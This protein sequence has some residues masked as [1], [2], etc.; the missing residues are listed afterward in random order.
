MLPAPD[1]RALVEHA[2][3]MLWRAGPEGGRDHF[4]AT[5]LAFTGRTLEEERGDGWLAGVHPEDR[6]GWAAAFR[7]HAATQSP[8][9]RDLRLR[10]RDGVHRWIR[11][12]AVP[13]EQGGRFAGFI[14]ACVDVHEQK[15]AEASRHAFL[16]MIAHELRTPLMSLR[17]AAHF[18]GKKLGGVEGADRPLGIIGRQ[19]DRLARTAFELAEV[20]RLERG[21]PPDLALVPLDLGPLVE[22]AARECFAQLE[23]QASG[24]TLEIAVSA[25]PCVSADAGR[26]SQVVH[27]LV[28]NAVRYSPGGGA[29][30]VSVVSTS[31]GALFSVS[32]RGVGI[33]KDEIPRVGTRYY[34]A[35]NAKAAHHRGVGA[36]LAVCRDV[37][38]AH[39]GTLALRS[40]LGEGTTAEVFLPAVAP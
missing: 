36:G 11:D 13:Y 28:D 15:L 22:V 31:G 6:E 24:H 20:A 10:R 18:L 16:A 14:G 32:D 27:A 12:R 21:A 2:P 4:N 25:A 1:Y 33:P 23:G 39:H 9:E 7:A 30:R 8:F 35:T 37:I 26:L 38:E 40:C 3:V 19:V 5:W 17:T 34:R 29:V